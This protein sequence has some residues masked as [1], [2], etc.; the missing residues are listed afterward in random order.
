MQVSDWRH[1]WVMCL[2]LAA[3][4]LLPKAGASAP[5]GRVV[6]W[7]NST[8]GQATVP[9]GLC[10]AVSISAGD[11]FSVAL[12]SDGTV[13]AW[14]NPGAGETDVPA[15]LSGVTAISCGTAGSHTLALKSNG[16]VV[17]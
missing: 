4:V 14:G 1:R 8:Y 5:P 16:T 13:V 10:N 12:R 2:F 3:G 6:T 11:V 7:G 17:A 9:A 15:A